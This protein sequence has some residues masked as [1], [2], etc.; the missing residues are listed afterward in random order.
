M[1]LLSAGRSSRSS[2]DKKSLVR[3]DTGQEHS[4][5]GLPPAPWL[6]ELNAIALGCILASLL[7]NGGVSISLSSQAVQKLGS[8]ARTS[9]LA[10]VLTLL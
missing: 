9:Q 1:S 8:L 3:K 7:W 5:L 6:P 2:I 10:T 4:A